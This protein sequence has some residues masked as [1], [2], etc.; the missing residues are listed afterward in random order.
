MLMNVDT[1]QTFVHLEHVS[2]PSE[3]INAIVELIHE[4][5]MFHINSLVSVSLI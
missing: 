4:D 3:V 1:S 5:C 2:I